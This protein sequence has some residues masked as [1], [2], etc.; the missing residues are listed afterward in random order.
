MQKHAIRGK[1]LAS[2]KGQTRG[3]SQP[4]IFLNLCFQFVSVS[5]YL[6]NSSCSMAK[7][8]QLPC[9]RAGHH[10]PY[11]HNSCYLPSTLSIWWYGNTCRLAVRA[12][13][14]HFHHAESPGSNVFFTECENKI[15]LGFLLNGTEA[16]MW[17]EANVSS[18]RWWPCRKSDHFVSTSSHTLWILSAFADLKSSS[19]KL[20]IFG[21]GP[22]N[23]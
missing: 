10:P 8:V 9:L 2:N 6:H 20:L 4:L 12:T 3:K 5:S 21:W 14:L 7:K 18:L 11:L 15:V 16:E 19:R 13:N 23:G 17:K 1:T 22:G